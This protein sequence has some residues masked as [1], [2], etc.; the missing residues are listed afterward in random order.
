MTLRQSGN[1]SLMSWADVKLIP[2]KPCVLSVPTHMVTGGGSK[3]LCIRDRGLATL[4]FVICYVVI[5]VIMM[6]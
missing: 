5:T 1:C 2:N 4:F 3:S 6:F